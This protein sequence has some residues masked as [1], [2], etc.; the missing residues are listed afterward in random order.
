MKI[1]TLQPALPHYRLD[2]FRKVHSLLGDVFSV[3]Y[4]P[5]RLAG[6][7]SESLSEPWAKRIGP[8]N[9]IMNGLEW[10]Q[11]AMEIPI[12]RGD[13]LVVCGAPRTLSTL[14][15]IGKARIKRAKVVWWGHY[16]S[17]TSKTWR[18]RLRINMLRFCH[19]VLFYTDKE[20]E[21]FFDNHAKMNFSC[22]RALNNG[23]NTEP[24]ERLRA[25]YEP[26]LRPNRILFI[27]R[28]TPKADLAFA[29]YALAAIPEE[30]RPT[31]DVIG[32]G[33]E[34]SRLAVQATELNLEN[35]V[36]WHGAITDEHEIAKIANCCRLFVYPGEAGLSLI[37]AMA[38]GLPA[39]VHSDR[40]KQMPEFAAFEDYVTGRS[41][42]REHVSSLAG[43]LT[44]MITN[45]FALSS[46]SAS[47]L[48]RVKET[49][50]TRDMANRFVEIIRMVGGDGAL[51]S[52]A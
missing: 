9:P 16:W 36:K 49:F 3:S 35:Y 33:E 42:H 17:S 22:V 43:I 14:A 38:Y 41:F 51:P 4:S 45:E 52:R 25:H 30:I 27:G 31:L 50:N 48:S 8:I 29:L 15:I 26:A 12:D 18:F 24:I 32:D 19:G 44:E 7:T 46:Y 21:E 11:G 28:L 2:F 5:T 34:R 40:W 39:V 6:I 20:V 37:H 47:A 23:I 13:I 1:I 10:Q